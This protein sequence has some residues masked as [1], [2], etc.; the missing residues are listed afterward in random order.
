MSS[1]IYKSFNAMTTKLAKRDTKARTYSKAFC[2]KITR[3]LI[4]SDR[5]SQQKKFKTYL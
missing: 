1:E 2:S 4:F 5:H 3:Q